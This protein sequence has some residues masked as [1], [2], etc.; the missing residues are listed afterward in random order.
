V[1]DDVYVN[2]KVCVCVC[3]CVCVFSDYIYCHLWFAVV[4]MRVIYV[5]SEYCLVY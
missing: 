4:M 5:R 2:A 3:V 1:S